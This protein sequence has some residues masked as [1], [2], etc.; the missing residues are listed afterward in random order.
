MLT[1]LQ[2]QCPACGEDAVL[3]VDL[4]D[5]AVHEERQAHANDAELIMAHHECRALQEHEPGPPEPPRRHQCPACGAWFLDLEKHK[6]KHR[7]A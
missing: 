3:E 6:C 5:P 7:P 4:S 2:T 1:K